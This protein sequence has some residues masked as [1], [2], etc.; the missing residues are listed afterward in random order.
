[1]ISSSKL[2]ST[3]WTYKLILV[4]ALPLLAAIYIFISFTVSISGQN[5][6]VSSLLTLTEARQ[7]AASTNLVAILRMQSILPS[8]IAADDKKEVR[9]Y[10]IATIKQKSTLEEYSNK[11]QEV[12]PNSPLVQELAELLSDIKPLQLRLIKYA[13]TNED[14]LALEVFNQIVP[15]IDQT[16]VISQAILKDEQRQITA[17]AEKNKIDGENIIQNQIITLVICI[18]FASLIT[19]FFIRQLLSSIGQ[20]SEAITEFSSGNLSPNGP[21]DLT[22]E[23][24]LIAQDFSLA[25][26]TIREVVS[27][28][29]SE[30]QGLLNQAAQLEGTAQS[31]ADT[32]NLILNDSISMSDKMRSVMS[33]AMNAREEISSSVESTEESRKNSMMTE[34]SLKNCVEQFTLLQNELEALSIDVS[35]LTISSAKIQSITASIRGISDQTNLLALNAAIEAARAGE[36]GRGFAVVADEVR[37][38]AHGS[39]AA[40]EEVSA[41]TEKMNHSVDSTVSKLDKTRELVIASL[42]AMN[43]AKEHSSV[44]QTRAE[45][46]K[47]KLDGV[48]ADSR[49]QHEELVSATE[50]SEELSQKVDENADKITKL[51]GMSG[52]LNSAAKRMSLLIEQFKQFEKH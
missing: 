25:V 20:I 34:A 49:T 12:L 43:Q 9:K 27:G 5:E 32:S 39:S 26:D 33:S 44:G 23:L 47:T 6:N 19:G 40:T 16:I 52:D 51:Y 38:L 8:L 13:N 1:M 50:I 37:N 21:H 17:L 48:L 24:A 7:S 29:F 36:L 46:S 4:A 18:I 42:E 45:T 30:S 15:I 22:G 11:L 31:S 28:I 14:V 35:D 41:I 2:S 3:S 10:A